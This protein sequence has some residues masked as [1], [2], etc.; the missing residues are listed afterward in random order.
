LGMLFYQLVIS[1]LFSL[2]IYIIR[3]EGNRR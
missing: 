2:R 1:E 3:A